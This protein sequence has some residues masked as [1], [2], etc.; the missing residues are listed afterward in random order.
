MKN[1]E[2]LKFYPHSCCY[3]NNNYD[4]KLLETS[5]C[6]VIV[7]RG[8]NRNCVSWVF[9]VVTSSVKNADVTKD[10]LT[11]DLKFDLTDRKSVV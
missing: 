2:A 8:V 5:L 1:I 9:P 7:C 11:V 10:I 6:V 3:E 4:S